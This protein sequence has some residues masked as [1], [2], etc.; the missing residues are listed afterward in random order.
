LSA[1]E[2]KKGGWMVRSCKERQP[3]QSVALIDKT[4]QQYVGYDHIPDHLAVG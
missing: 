4:G 3:V 2:Q 1:Q